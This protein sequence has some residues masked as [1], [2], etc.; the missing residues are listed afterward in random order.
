MKENI[1]VCLIISI[2]G[3]ILKLLNNSVKNE[4]ANSLVNTVIS[5]IVLILILS[6]F[7]GI[8]VSNTDFEAVQTISYEELEKQTRQT[9]IKDA[10]SSISSLIK[11][12]FEL[13]FNAELVKCEIILDYNNLSISKLILYCCNNSFL[14]TYD[15]IKVFKTKYNV[16][17]EVIFI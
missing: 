13:N 14:S 16:I 3:T 12:E 4:K 10:E 2:L 9:I 17:P 1:T 11:D 15:V 7:S 8:K 5:A 6:G